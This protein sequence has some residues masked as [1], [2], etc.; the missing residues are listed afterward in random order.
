MS[1]W[2]AAILG[3]NL[4]R[5]Y[6]DSRGGCVISAEQIQFSRQFSR[7]SFFF[8]F[9]WRK[10]EPSKATR[11]W[12]TNFLQ[13][14]S[15]EQR[16]ETKWQNFPSCLKSQ[17]CTDSC[18][19]FM[20][21][22]EHEV[23]WHHVGRLRVEG[24]RNFYSWYLRFIFPRRWQQRNAYDIGNRAIWSKRDFRI[25]NRIM[26]LYACFCILLRSLSTYS[27]NV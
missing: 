18:W 5:F 4:A 11:L 20:D 25:K 3:K 24:E 9:R 8:C 21:R 17:G 26:F 1:H 15:L 2:D 10:R 27:A 13:S 19:I 14:G 23:K 16:G 22:N 12:L 7:C 6:I